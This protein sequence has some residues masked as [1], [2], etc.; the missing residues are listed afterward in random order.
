MTFFCFFF[1]CHVHEQYATIL[2]TWLL[3]YYLNVPML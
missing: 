1:D 2:D 3:K